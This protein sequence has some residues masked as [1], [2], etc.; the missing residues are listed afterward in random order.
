MHT[1]RTECSDIL[2]TNGANAYLRISRQSLRP[3]PA[4]TRAQYSTPDCSGDPPAAD[5]VAVPTRA[6]E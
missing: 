3:I 1:E 6:E 5:T 2:E 4:Y